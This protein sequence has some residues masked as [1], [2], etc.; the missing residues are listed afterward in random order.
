MDIFDTSCG[1]YPVGHAVMHVPTYKLNP[2]M[3]DLQYVE[4]TQFPHG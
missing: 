2:D 3:H 1:M 4:F